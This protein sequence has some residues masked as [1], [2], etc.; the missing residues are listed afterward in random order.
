MLVFLIV[1]AVLLAGAVAALAMGRIGGG[2][3]FAMAPVPSRSGAD[4]LAGVGVTDGP[5][6][7]DAS[8]EAD[9]GGRMGS[10]HVAAMRFDRA[11][12]GYRM[13]QVDAVLDR[14]AQEL[15]RRD[16]II[17]TLRARLPDPAVEPWPGSGA[18]PSAEASPPEDASPRE[19]SPPRDDVGET[20]G[21]S[22]QSGPRS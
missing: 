9:A 17:A 15:G 19:G 3:S 18:A 8:G 1:V 12:R 6:D 22:H 13:D 16:E 4:V 14:V 10:V 21:G 11:P 5:G 7:L 2:A 20:P